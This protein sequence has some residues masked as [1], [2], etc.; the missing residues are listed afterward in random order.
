M[1]LGFEETEYIVDE[2]DTVIVNVVVLE[3]EISG[4]VRVRVTTRDGSATSK[5]VG[6]VKKLLSYIAWYN[7]TVSIFPHYFFRSRGLRQPK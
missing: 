1:V 7:F 5:A 3:G 6:V 4:I 2:N